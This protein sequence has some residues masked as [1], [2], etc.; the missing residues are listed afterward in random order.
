MAVKLQ[1]HIVWLALGSIYGVG[2]WTLRNLYAHSVLDVISELDQ[3]ELR[4]RLTQA[5]CKVSG[6]VASTWKKQSGWLLEAAQRELERLASN[7]I[8]LIF[9]NEDEFPPVLRNIKD[10]P[11][12]LIVHGNVDL[13][14]QPSVAVVGTRKPTEEGIDLARQVGDLFGQYKINTISGLAE[15]IDITVQ[16][17]VLQYHTPTVA[18]LGHGINVE[19][20]A[21]TF[22][23]RHDIVTAGGAV[24]S[25]Y[26][27][28]TKYNKH[29]FVWRNR[30][31]AGLAH[32][33]IPVEWQEKSGTAHTI[34]FAKSFGRQL[35]GL[36][37]PHWTNGHPE[38]ELI[39]KLGGVVYILP[40]DE[41]KILSRVRNPDI[42]TNGQ[43]STGE[44][45]LLFKDR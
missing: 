35:I 24:I 20:P 44:Q 15:G 39:R 9:T 8:R 21:G 7:N 16:K 12:W 6:K 30:L 43:L 33:V 4:R 41:D 29:F 31:Q 19:F 5:G 13:L 25:E 45:L 28:A 38:L 11:F 3:T 18:V 26:L 40:G 14:S 37:S 1:Q 34:G 27:P 10:P 23:T 42:P 22:Q 2:Y 17:Q 36:R 32:T